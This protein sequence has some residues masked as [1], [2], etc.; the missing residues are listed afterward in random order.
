MEKSS[1]PR[2][3]T[4][5]P[6]PCRLD[7]ITLLNRISPF[8]APANGGVGWRMRGKK[9]ALRE[10]GHQQGNKK[11]C[12]LDPGSFKHVGNRCAT[13][14]DMGGQRKHTRVGSWQDP[15]S[16]AGCLLLLLPE[17][18]QGQLGDNPSAPLGA[19]LLEKQMPWLLKTDQALDCFLSIN[20]FVAFHVQSMSYSVLCL[21]WIQTN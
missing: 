14:V 7:A 12:C 9:G 3:N 17:G 5:A 11:I 19:S 8:P 13:W 6:V 16:T 10:E 15:C 4:A 18:A 21:Q 20:Q 2:K 1:E